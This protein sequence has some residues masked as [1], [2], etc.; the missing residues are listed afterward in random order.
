MLPEYAIIREA[1]TRI[2]E[3]ALSTVQDLRER[4][5]EHREKEVPAKSRERGGRLSPQTRHPPVWSGFG[6][7]LGGFSGQNSRVGPRMG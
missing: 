7:L 2:A 3:A 5:I 6:A 4:L 1:A